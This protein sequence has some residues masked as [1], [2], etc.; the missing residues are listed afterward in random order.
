MIE[1]ISGVV[2]LVIFKIN[3]HCVILVF[4]RQIISRFQKFKSI[5]EMFLSFN[6]FSDY[7]LF[8]EKI[9]KIQIFLPNHFS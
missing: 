8:T 4:K 3:S 1:E 2:L 7:K 6:G 5:D 9:L